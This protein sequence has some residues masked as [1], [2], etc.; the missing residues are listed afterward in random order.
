[1]TIFAWF[2]IFERMVGRKAAS[3]LMLL[4]FAGIGIFI[5]AMIYG[6]P[7]TPRQ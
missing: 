3:Y 1:M 2:I 4:M 6:A 5:I 7:A